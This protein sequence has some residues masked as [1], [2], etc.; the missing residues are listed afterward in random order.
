MFNEVRNLVHQQFDCMKQTGTLFRVEPDR[1]QIWSIYLA[2]IPEE[3]RQSNTCNC[4]K[5]FLRQFGGIVA[6][7]EK[8]QL[9]TLWDFETTDTEYS[10]A[11]KVVGNY[12][13]S[14]PIVGLFLNPF[15][16]LGSDKT[17]DGKREIIWTHYYL[18]LP[19]SFVATETAIGPKQSEATTNKDVL[20]RSLNELT[21]DSTDT[22]L[23][24]IGQGSIYRGDQFLAMLTDFRALQRRYGKVSAARRTNWCWRESV[25]AGPAV[26]RIR[27]TSI[28]T[29]L[30]DLSEGKDLNQAVSAF[31]RAMAPANYKRPTALV[32]PRMVDAAKLRLEEM[33]LVGALNRRLLDDRDLSV[34]DVLFVHRSKKGGVEQDIF[35]Q[36]KSDAVIN[37]KSFA[38]V[39]ELSMTDFVTGVLPTAKSV[40]V[41]LDN[42]HL[43]NFVSLVGPQNPAEPSLFPWGNNY[44]WSYSGEVADSVKERVKAAGGK[45]D[46]IIRLSLSWHNH[47]DLDLHLMQPDGQ[48]VHFRCKQGRSGATLDVDMNAGGGHTREPVEN[49]CFANYP[50]Q[51]GIYRLFV[52]NWC[53]RESRDGGFEIEMEFDG[54]IWNLAFPNNGSTGK[55]FDVLTFTYSRKN[56]LSVQGGESKAGQYP[57]KEKWGLKT[58]Q[59]HNVRSITT[60]P[61]FWNGSLGHKHWFFFLEGCT[62]DEKTRGFYNEFLKP[63]LSKDRKVFEVLGGKAVVS[64]AEGRELSGIGFSDTVRKQMIVEVEGAFKRTLKINF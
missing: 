20:M 34:A 59:F 49:I 18:D 42:S 53:W 1:D 46:G 6:L 15:V 22:V 32:T 13:R 56:G 9:V 16:R 38:K 57:S 60:S 58:G 63:E 8:D 40:R 21:E 5:S 48:D 25:S 17:P 14:L 4:C 29:L 62:S 47:D 10:G 30:I 51:E 35:A 44:S 39:E 33:G 36:V 54:Q 55:N 23:E 2:A 24:L 64:P 61:N 11:I 19:A 27:N 52:N 41:L 37:P 31:E 3:H 43:P 12:I 7:G 26:T 45:V 28:G 50:S